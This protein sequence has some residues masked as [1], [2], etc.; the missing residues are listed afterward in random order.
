M[1]NSEEIIA[2]SEELGIVGYVMPEVEGVNYI[3]F[4]LDRYKPHKTSGHLSIY[5][6]S[7]SLPLEEHEFTYSKHLDNEPVSIFFDQEGT[8]ANK[9]VVIEQ[10]KRLGEI[11]ENSYGMEY[12]VSN[13]KA[14]YLLAVNW[15][16]IEGAGTAVDWINTLRNN[17]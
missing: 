17:K 15:Y 14:D 3:R 8:E 2:A 5:Y 16:V 12:F 10:G 11:F 7:V 4:V 6:N 9:V 13:K 1:N